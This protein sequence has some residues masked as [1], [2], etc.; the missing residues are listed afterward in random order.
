ML[1]DEEELLGNK[2]E[3]FGSKLGSSG[4]YSFCDFLYVLSSVL[5]VFLR[6]TFSNQQESNPKLAN[7]FEYFCDRFESGMFCAQVQIQF[8][9]F[10]MFS[11]P[12][13]FQPLL[14]VLKNTLTRYHGYYLYSFWLHW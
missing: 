8:C 3:N 4:T 7:S 5:L 9:T 11:F 6:L 10:T 13:L 2:T 1:S 12:L 14:L